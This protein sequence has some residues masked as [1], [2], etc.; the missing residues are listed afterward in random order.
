MHHL[1]PCSLLANTL[2]HGLERSHGD[3]NENA[4]ARFHVKSSVGVIQGIV[5]L[6]SKG[7]YT[8]PMSVMLAGQFQWKH[9][10]MDTYIYIPLIVPL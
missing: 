5:L 9:G 4:H 10:A 2:I 1:L 7:F 6:L 3:G 8:S